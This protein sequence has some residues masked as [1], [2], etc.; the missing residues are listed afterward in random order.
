MFT[1]AEINT[2]KELA[3]ANWNNEDTEIGFEYNGQWIT[4]PFVDSS[5]RLELV[6]YEAMCEYYGRDNVEGFIKKILSE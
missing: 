5:A 6:N 1:T 4:N 3:Y 2:A